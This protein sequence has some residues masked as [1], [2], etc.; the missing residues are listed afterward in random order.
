MPSFKTAL[1]DIKIVFFFKD[2]ASF[3]RCAYVLRISRWS[4]NLGNPVHSNTN[5]FLRGL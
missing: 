1:K 3:C 4:E 5:V 2:D